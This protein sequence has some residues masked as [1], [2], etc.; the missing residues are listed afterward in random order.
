M[1][2]VIR[3]TGVTTVIRVTRVTRVIRVTTVISRVRCTFTF[4]PDQRQR[5]AIPGPSSPRGKSLLLV[6]SVFVVLESTT[7]SPITTTAAAAAGG[8]SLPALIQLGRL[9]RRAQGEN[10]AVRGIDGTDKELLG[11]HQQGPGQV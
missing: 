2:R 7:T 3:V 9:V 4:R 6:F 8:S 1:T 11:E 5:G 10:K